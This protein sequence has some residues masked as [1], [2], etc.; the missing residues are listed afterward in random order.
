VGLV[1]A[2]GLH[3]ITAWILGLTKARP[4]WFGP[5]IAP[6]FIVSA[7]VSAL[8]LLVFS[9]VGLRRILHLRIHDEVIRKLGIM[10]T[11]S[12]PVLGYF[13][14]AELL[15]V[16]YGGE[17][18]AL[19]VFRTMM[20]GYHAPV[21]W[22]NLVFGLLFPFLLLSLVLG[23]VS[24][25]WV[26]AVGL[27]LLPP[28]AALAAVWH[29]P[30]PIGPILGIELPVW[31]TYAGLW[32]FGVLLL[33]FCASENFGLDLRIGL[34]GLLVVVGVL[35]ERWNIVVPSLI[36][37]SYVPY[38]EASY[39]PTLPELTLV[40]GVYAMGGLFF[41]ACAFLLPLVESEEET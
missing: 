21:F 36:G 8:A 25:R 18:G 40:T 3:T 39:H 32:F 19:S 20:Y 22:G 27:A 11:I 38:P 34:A 28:F 26:L 16:F 23:Q 9:V 12:I 7:T 14:F 35:A 31:A 1:G 30:V 4:G 41:I 13:L 2:V 6:L 24:V 17:P 15:T 33:S 37:H 10:L 5:M 29:F